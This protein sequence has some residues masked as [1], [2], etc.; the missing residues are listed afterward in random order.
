[1]DLTSA[2]TGFDSCHGVQNTE[3][4]PSDFKVSC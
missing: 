3:G 1:M 4:E 2:P